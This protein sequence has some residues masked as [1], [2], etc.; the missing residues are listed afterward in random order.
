MF[1]VVG[2][3]RQS[4]CRRMRRNQRVVLPD[5]TASLRQRRGDGSKPIGG[6]LSER[7]HRL[8]AGM[9]GGDA[10]TC[11]DMKEVSC[12]AISDWLVRPRDDCG[13]HPGWTDPFH[14]AGT[15][16]GAGSGPGASAADS[17]RSSNSLRLGSRS[18]EV[19]G[20]YESRRGPRRGGQFEGPH[21]RS[22]SSGELDER[23]VVRERV[24]AVV[25]VRSERQI[26][27]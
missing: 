25:R 8:T 19:F 22:Q 21:C 11:G 3:Q 14:G 7:M 2:H 18:A 17:E 12:E 1:G 26:P 23:S 20:R 10:H 9:S 4:Q 15:G 13:G 24:D 16:A 27:A 5:R 6:L